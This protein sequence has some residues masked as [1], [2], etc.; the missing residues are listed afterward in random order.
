MLVKLVLSILFTVWAASSFL[1]FENRSIACTHRFCLT[2]ALERD[3]DL[4]PAGSRFVSRI[5][6]VLYFSMIGHTR[7]PPRL[8][9]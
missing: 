6:E 1:I 9:A 4:K 7:T 8:N 5:R 3:E 2:N